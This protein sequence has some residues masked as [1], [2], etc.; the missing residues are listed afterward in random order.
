MRYFSRTRKPDV[1]ETF[2]IAYLPLPELVGQVDDLVIVVPDTPQTISMINT[3]LL[4]ACREPLSVINLSRPE[5]IAPEALRWGLHNKRLESVWFDD[6][7]RDP[8][9]ELIELRKDPRVKVTPHIAS[10]TYDA[11]DAMSAMAVTSMLN[12]L[13]GGSDQHIINAAN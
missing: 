1:E 10:L 13:C 4:A 8:S 12:V 9:P 5:I 7:Y 2:K 3:D 11:R 6:Y